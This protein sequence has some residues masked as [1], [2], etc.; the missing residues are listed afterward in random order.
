ME[1]I[2]ETTSTPSMYMPRQFA[3]DQLADALR[4]MRAHP[5]AS[6]T[7]VDADGFPFVSYLP[8]HVD[9]EADSALTLWGH[10]ARGNPQWK[11]LA[12][13]PQALVAFRGAHSYLS[14]TVYPDLQRVPTWDYVVVHCRVQVDLVDEVDD[15]DALL[16][17]LIADH[18]PAYAEQWRGLDTDYARKM[19]GA[20]V[21][22]RMRVLGWECKLKVNQHRP[23]S[24]DKLRAAYAQ[25]A[26]QGDP[27][28]QELI[29]WMDRLAA[30]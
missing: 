8:L 30:R 5:L 4:V 1:I 9:A 14:P 27:N 28:A 10:C 13:N 3:S 19:L 24:F 18:E 16:K 12:Q 20:I 25:R 26:A 29:D 17:R 2:P 11:L 15:K 23:E 21:G 6:M 7:S 22:L